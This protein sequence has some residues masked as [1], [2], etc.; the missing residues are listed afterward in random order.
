ML[1]F[2][3]SPFYGAVKAIFGLSGSGSLDKTMPKLFNHFK[4][5]SVKRPIGGLMGRLLR[6]KLMDFIS[7][8]ESNHCGLRRKRKEGGTPPII[9][10]ANAGTKA[11]QFDCVATISHHHS[12]L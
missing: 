9:V 5:C 6:V 4:S 3:V 8:F 7:V 1:L 10:S 12:G 2:M 11:I